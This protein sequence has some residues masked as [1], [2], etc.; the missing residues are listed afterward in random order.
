MQ[1]TTIQRDAFLAFPK[2]SATYYKVRLHLHRTLYGNTSRL[3]K[4]NQNR[5]FGVLELYSH[6]L[7]PFLATYINP[8]IALHPWERFKFGVSNVDDCP[9]LGGLLDTIIDATWLEAFLVLRCLVAIPQ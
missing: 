9:F 4:V 8:M 3:H 5:F 7:Q 2:A 6:G 1:K